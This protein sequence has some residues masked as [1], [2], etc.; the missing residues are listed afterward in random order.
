M[1]KGVIKRA[2]RYARERGMPLSR[3][4]ESYLDH[5][6][7]PRLMPPVEMP[8]LLRSMAGILKDVDIGDYKKHLSERYMK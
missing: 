8:P 6:T 1:D 3:I 4:V 7:A 5:V 2:K